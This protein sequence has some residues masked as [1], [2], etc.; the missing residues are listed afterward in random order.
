L[1]DLENW[2]QKG[3]TGR[4]EELESWGQK[5]EVRLFY[6][7]IKKQNKGF[8]PRVDFYRDRMGNQIGGKED[9]KMGWREYFEEILYIT[10][11]ENPTHR[12]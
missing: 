5:G 3:E 12:N 1:E 7:M 9:V 4:L 6:E 2:G 11:E 10:E 8:Q